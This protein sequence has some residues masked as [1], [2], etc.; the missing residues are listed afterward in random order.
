[1]PAL[2]LKDRVIQKIYGTY[3]KGQ[4][5]HRLWITINQLKDAA[6]ENNNINN[7]L[8]EFQQ[9]KKR[10][11]LTSITM[12]KIPHTVFFWWYKKAINYNHSRP[13]SYSPAQ[14]LHLPF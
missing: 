10:S 3:K 8:L 2:I 13:Y 4:I 5:T 7:A 6:A 11:Q 1:M 9:T 14:L 12:L